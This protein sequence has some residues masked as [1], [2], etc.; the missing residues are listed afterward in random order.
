MAAILLAMQLV[1]P[2]DANI[3]VFIDDRPP[4]GYTSLDWHNEVMRALGEWFTPM[5]LSVTCIGNIEDADI[6]IRV[7]DFVHA[8]GRTFLPRNYLFPMLPSKEHNVQ[9]EIAYNCPNVRY[10]LLHEIGHSIGLKHREFSVM[11]TLERIPQLTEADFQSIAI[12]KRN[13]EL[14]GIRCKR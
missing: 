13:I 4:V 6:K 14:S 7:A 11:A 9:I 2:Q 3:S 1:V 5:H 8:D 12:I 10:A